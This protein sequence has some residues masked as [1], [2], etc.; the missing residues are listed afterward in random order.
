MG[1]KPPSFPPNHAPIMRESQQLFFELRLVNRIFEEFQHLAIQTK[2]VQHFGEYF[3]QIKVRQPR[4]RKD[5]IQTVIVTIRRLDSCLY[6]FK[7]EINKS[8]TYSG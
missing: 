8:K 5:S 1:H 4:G 3:H 6:A 7:S 2:V